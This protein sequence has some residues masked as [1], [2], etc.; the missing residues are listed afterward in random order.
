[1]SKRFA[2]KNVILSGFLD[3]EWICHLSLKVSHLM[4]EIDGWTALSLVGIWIEL[5]YNSTWI[6]SQGELHF[7]FMG[8]IQNHIS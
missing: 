6:A 7:K 8:N 1:M 3:G 2:F 5:A 4:D